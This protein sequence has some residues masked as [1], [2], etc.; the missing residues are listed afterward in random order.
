MPTLVV[1][2][3]GR[4]LFLNRAAE[5]LLAFPADLGSIG[6]ALSGLCE[7]ALA[8]QAQVHSKVD[9]GPGPGQVQAIAAPLREA[10][11]E[12]VVVRLSRRQPGVDLDALAAGLAHELR[13][14][15]AGLI[16]AAEL[17]AAELPDDSP[18]VAYSALIVEEAARINRLAGSLLDL[19][20]PPRLR[21]EPENLHA[22]CEHVLELARPALPG[23]IRVTRRY[24]PSLPDVPVDR[25]AVVQLVLNLVKNASEAMDGGAGELTV[26]TGAVSGMH[27]R[28]SGA[29]RRLVRIAVLDEGPGVAEDLEVFTPF[30]ST[31]PRGT[32]LGLAIARRL[33]DAHG[34]RLV[35]RNR[36]GR[37]GAEAELLLPLDPPKGSS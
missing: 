32:G 26:E 11:R 16:G 28:E 14:P 25:D 37:Q 2:R 3:G 27:L 30:A 22:I 13:N 33:A 9:L 31:K 10:A 19:T 8:S 34:G 18:L 7:S 23:G 36:R 35:L 24:D 21:V 6:A 17:M 29:S 20:K 5:G 12:A 15:L 4:I 1:E